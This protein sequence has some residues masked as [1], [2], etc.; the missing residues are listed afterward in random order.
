MQAMLLPNHRDGNA[1]WFKYQKKLWWALGDN[2]T[3][4][5][6]TLSKKRVFIIW[7]KRFLGINDPFFLFYIFCFSGSKSELEI[8]VSV[9]VLGKI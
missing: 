6:F 9:L 1:S 5:E 2:S 3:N 4:L 7:N 8:F